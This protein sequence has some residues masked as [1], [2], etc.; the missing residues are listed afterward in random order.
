VLQPYLDD[1]DC[2]Q[3]SPLVPLDLFFNGNDDTGSIGCNLASHPEIATFYDALR[4][5]RSDGEVSGV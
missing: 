5:L 4:Q 1:Q 3:P 2:Y